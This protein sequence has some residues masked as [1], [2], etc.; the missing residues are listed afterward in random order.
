MRM[1]LFLTTFSILYGALH[2]YALMRAVG[3]LPLG[4]GVWLVLAMFMLLM[5]IS[6]MII[7]YLEKLG[8]DTAALLLAYIGFLWMAFLFLFV[9]AGLVE[10]LYRLI[11]HFGGSFLRRDLSWMILSRKQALFAT[12]IISSLITVYGYFE[13]LNIKT[14]RVTLASPKISS[15]IG[16]VRIVQISDV[17]L[18]LMM[19]E[20]RVKRIVE[21]V[22]KAEPD[23]LVATGDL[24]DSQMDNLKIFGTML[25]DIPAKYGKFAVT[26]NHEFYAGLPRSLDLMKRAGFTVL[27]GEVHDVSGILQIA[28]VDDPAGNGSG[29][30]GGI[31]E[32][33]LLSSLPKE[34]YTILLKHR[35]VIDD[36][37]VGLFDLQLSGH[38][39]KGQIF[40]FTLIIKLLYPIDA[41]LLSLGNCSV[42]YVNRGTGT[43]GPPIRFLAPPEITVIELVHAGER[44]AVGKSASR[45]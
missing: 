4:R 1:I 28:G 16:R 21:A 44:G 10:D 12:L 35:P 24:V 20:E 9:C 33:A 22:R 8:L 18:W 37:A 2:F 38:S 43:W 13:A 7:R 36:R 6:P 41:G 31:S 14:E 11:L 15:E 23:I 17:H 26:G 30:G 34:K 45:R 3:A 19:S 32:V 29:A 39:H 25:R 40:P 27:R 42:L 5:I